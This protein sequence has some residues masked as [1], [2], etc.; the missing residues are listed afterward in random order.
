MI[1][2]L[3]IIKS[4]P[5]LFFFIILTLFATPPDSHALTLRWD[6]VQDQDLLSYK[7]Y[8]GKKSGQY[9]SSAYVGTETEYK[10]SLEESS[11]YYLTVTAIDLWGNESNYGIELKLENG[12]AQPV[13]REKA[14]TVIFPNPANDHVS[15]QFTLDEQQ[16]VRISI[17]NIM[18]QKVKTLTDGAYSRGSHAVDWDRTAAG[19]RFAAAGVYYCRIKTESLTMVR[20][21]ILL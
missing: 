7:V 8:W 18:G 12:T 20:K 2:P 15:V 13:N 5:L 9:T 11:T 17:Y 19:G 14:G 3:L 21:L 16:N 4:I 10:L 6:P 1:N